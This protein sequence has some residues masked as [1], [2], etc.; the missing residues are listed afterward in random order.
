MKPGLPV[1]ACAIPLLCLSTM[2]GCA[3]G[4]VLTILMILS[5]GLLSLSVRGAPATMHRP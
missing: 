5:V 3:S 2:E 1:I 4:T